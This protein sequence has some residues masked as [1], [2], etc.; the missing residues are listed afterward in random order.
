MFTTSWRLCLLAFAVLACASLQ[1]RPPSQ[2]NQAPSEQSD[3]VR[4]LPKTP[5]SQPT[6][7]LTQS[8]AKK[9]ESG[10]TWGSVP[11]WLVVAITGGGVWAAF[12]SLDHIRTQAKA[13]EDAAIAAKISADVV[14]QTLRLAASTFVDLSGFSVKPVM[15]NSG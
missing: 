1:E 5:T 10:L 2:N 9:Q 8:Q 3:P 6:T 14:N 4:P 12:R 15:D 13:A 11:D 7:S